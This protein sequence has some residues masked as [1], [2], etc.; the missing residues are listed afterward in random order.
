MAEFTDN[1]DIGEYFRRWMLNVPGVSQIV[2]E[3]VIDTIPESD[4]CGEPFIWYS[5]D[6]A[7]DSECFEE[8]FDDYDYTVEIIASRLRSADT[9]K[10]K[11]LLINA[12]Q[13]YKRGD[14]FGSPD[15]KIQSLEVM[16]AKDDF[17]PTIVNFMKGISFSVLHVQITP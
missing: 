10:L 12:C 7:T 11:T 5:L 14:E 9:R 6:D 3:K 17:L 2:G 15:F 1:C 16:R 13:S 8:G 4:S